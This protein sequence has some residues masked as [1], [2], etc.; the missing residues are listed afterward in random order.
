[1]MHLLSVNLLRRAQ[2]D[3]IN[4]STTASVAM[5]P[6]AAPIPSPRAEESGPW[7]KGKQ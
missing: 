2:T 6:A 7:I 5:A 4:M 1:M 3:V